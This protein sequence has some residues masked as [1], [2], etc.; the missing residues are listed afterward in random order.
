MGGGLPPE[1]SHKRK[2]VSQKNKADS[3][4]GNL[5]YGALNL[6]WVCQ[7]VTRWVVST[8]SGKKILHMERIFAGRVHG[9]KK[10][11]TFIKDEGKALQKAVVISVR[12]D[13]GE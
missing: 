12:W 11:I 7:I 2:R 8:N 3:R 4:D 9:V 10:I 1:G 6:S 13:G 5:R